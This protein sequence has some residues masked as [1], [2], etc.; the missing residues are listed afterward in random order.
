MGARNAMTSSLNIIRRGIE[1]A[2]LLGVP[3]RA[4]NR[5]PKP[6]G[7]A[8]LRTLLAVMVYAAQLGAFV[9][10]LSHFHGSA[11]ATAAAQSSVTAQQG[12]AGAEE[13]CLQCL[14]FAQVTSAAAGQRF[15]APIPDGH[16]VAV[17]PHGTHVPNSTHLVYLA[18]GP[19]QRA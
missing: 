2:P 18:R 5:L 7:R 12:A 3:A 4:R 16:V 6:F 13:F 8:A 10:A 14:A 19:P 15:E 11:L 1:A 9:H 17:T